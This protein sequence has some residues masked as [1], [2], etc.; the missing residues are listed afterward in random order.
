M[1][2]SVRSKCPEKVR[3]FSLY[4]ITTFPILDIM[5]L[6]YNKKERKLKKKKAYGE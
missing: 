4:I 5:D 1:G 6:F 3:E 2:N